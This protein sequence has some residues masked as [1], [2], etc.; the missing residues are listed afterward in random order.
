MKNE[1]NQA[2]ED[3]LD[4]MEYIQTFL[5]PS[6]MDE[7]LWKQKER[8]QI[9]PIILKYALP[10]VENNANPNIMT[11][12]IKEV[13]CDKENKSMKEIDYKDIYQNSR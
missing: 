7:R 2:D 12:A 11:R 9:Q 8:N 5:Q 1:P 4:K 3:K 6:K 10:Y 13:I